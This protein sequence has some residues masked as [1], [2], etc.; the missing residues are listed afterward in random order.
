MTSRVVTRS[1][2]AFVVATLGWLLL[3]PSALGGS[4]VYVTTHGISMQPRFHTGDL[5]VLRPASDYRVGN[6][7]A[8]DSKVMHTVVMHRIVAINDGRYT[9]KGDNN[10]WLDPEQPNRSQLLGKLAVR[11]PQ[12]GVWLRRLTSPPALALLA[13][14]LFATGATSV[15]T[16][17]SRRKRGTVSRHAAPRPR[18]GKQGLL[19]ALPPALRTTSAIAAGAALLA[20]ALG[21]FAWTAPASVASTVTS[22][23]SRSMAF[24]YTATVAKT[25]AYDGT[26][27]TS[28]DP[29]FRR[30]TNTVD[31]HY[32][33]TGTPGTLS[34]AVRASSAGGWHS[35]FPLQPPEHIG[36]RYA[37]TVTLDLGQIDSRAHA[38]AAV[39]GLP[40]DQL[41]VTV[42][43]MVD[44]AGGGSF[45]PSL[46]LTLTPLVLSYNGTPKAL[47][48]AGATTQSRQVLAPRRLRLPFG[49]NMT[50]PAARTLSAAL[51]LAALLAGA[52]V[53]GLARRS[54][55]NG[56]GARIRR[57]YAPL[58]VAVQPAPMAA[59]RP[60]VDVTEFGTLVR[61]AERYGLLILHWSRS[62]VETFVVQDDATTYRYRTGDA[63]TR[64]GDDLDTSPLAS[65]W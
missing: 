29:V 51:L 3:A 9:F 19:T 6:V 24:S 37:G 40:A 13:L 27:V 1:A 61:I 2:V 22:Q 46:P 44:V 7:V 62:N 10:S 41:T 11:I 48:V 54:P 55:T 38:A 14:A 50:V 63:T 39:T 47:T 30:L 31:V 18:A 34:I 59:G 36:A 23:Q 28:P 21:A 45:T 57:R 56:E 12:G 58:L 33:Y 17:R 15:R 32:T 49:R 64:S 4:A 60:L 5:A 8:Y 35:T 43:A 52:V 65:T 42:A 26:A 16:R 25:A 20:L 53:A